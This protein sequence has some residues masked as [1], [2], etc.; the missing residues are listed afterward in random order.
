MRIKKIPLQLAAELMDKNYSFVRIGLQRGILPFGSAIKT[1]EDNV[2]GRYTYYI[3][4][5]LVMDY[6]GYTEDDIVAAAKAGG[7]SLRR[8]EKDRQL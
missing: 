7:Y 8:F 1:H 3:S 2:Y 6:T 5:R 4:P